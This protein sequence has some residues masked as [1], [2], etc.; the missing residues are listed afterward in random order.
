MKSYVKFTML[1]AG[2]AAFLL[3]GY[4]GGMAHAAKFPEKPIRLIIMFPPGGSNDVLGRFL[5]SKITERVH[6]QVVIDNRGGAN[7]LIATKLAVNSDPDGYTLLFVSTSWVM[8]AALNRYD[9]DIEKR[10]DPIATLGSSANS[11]VVNP[12]WGVNDV[13]ELVRRAKAKPGSISYGSSGIGGFNH[14]GGELF[15]NLAGINLLHVP[16]KGGSPAMIDVAGGQIPMMFSSIL[17]ALPLVRA[18][19]LKFIGIGS[20]TRTPVLPDV[21]TIAE[22]G[23]PDYEV[24]VWWGVA[25]PR[26]IPSEQ[27][28]VLEKT[29]GAVVRDPKTKKRLAADAG[30]PMLTS[31][32]EFKT[33][34]S[35]EI[36]KWRKVAKDAKITVN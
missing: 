17:Q 21:P 1:I 10:F 22:Q 3:S 36:K 14:F 2:C 30:D 31:P 5:G 8:N 34:I 7:G 11:I 35:D 4:S 25:A 32:K 28:S 23:F 6:Q 12:K 20:K 19:K 15:K 16:Y 13:K 26:G 24:R 27:L 9:F 18:G 29:I 33:M